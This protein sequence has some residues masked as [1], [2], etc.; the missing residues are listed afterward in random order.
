MNPTTIHTLHVTVILLPTPAARPMPQTPAPT[1]G[2]IEAFEDWLIDRLCDLET[3]FE[4][5]VTESSSRF[6][7]QRR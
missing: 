6:H 2:G 7:H 4:S 3:R 1:T 5:Y